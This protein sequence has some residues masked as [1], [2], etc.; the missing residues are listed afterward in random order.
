MTLTCLFGTVPGNVFFPACVCELGGYTIAD[1]SVCI[2]T[3]SSLLLLELAHFVKQ[4]T[5]H[6]ICNALVFLAM[7]SAI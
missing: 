7:S 4:I 3:S 5:V 2:S 6:V 1:H